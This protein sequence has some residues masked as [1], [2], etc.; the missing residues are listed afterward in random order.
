MSL[1]F[2]S[3]LGNCKLHYPY[4]MLAIVAKVTR[5]VG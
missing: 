1:L 5:F 3:L 2:P 4:Y